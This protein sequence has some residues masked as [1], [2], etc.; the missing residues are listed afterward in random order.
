M[1]LVILLALFGVAALAA[2]AMASGGDPRPSGH[3]HAQA[4]GVTIRPLAGTT[5]DEEVRAGSG[6]IQLR[7][8]GPKAMLTAEITVEPGGTFGWHSHPGPVLVGIERGTFELVR[9]ENRRCRTH[10]F[11][12]GDGFVE[13]GGRVHLG[14]NAGSEP[15]RIFATFLARRGTTVFSQPEDPPEA[16]R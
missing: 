8:N 9:V 12:A 2:S 5:I 16:C 13:N 4:R 3:D 14:R 11:G 10:T 15:V 6:G 1:R 7:T